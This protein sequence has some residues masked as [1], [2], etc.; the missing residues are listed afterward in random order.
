MENTMLSN[1]SIKSSSFPPKERELLRTRDTYSVSCIPL[2]Q[3]SSNLFLK[4]KTI[5]LWSSNVLILLFRLPRRITILSTEKS[6]ENEGI[7]GQILFSLNSGWI[8]LHPSKKYY[9][10][11]LKA[12]KSAYSC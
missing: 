6:E 8:G 11:R 3:L 10:Q 9:I 12:R 5:S 4:Q 1:L 7:R 2:L